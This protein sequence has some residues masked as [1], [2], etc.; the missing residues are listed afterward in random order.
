V[1]RF[2]IEWGVNQRLLVTPLDRPVKPGD[3]KFRMKSTIPVM[4]GLG[5]LLSGLKFDYELP[6]G[7]W[8][9][10]R[11]VIAPADTRRLILARR[12]FIASMFTSGMMIAASVRRSG[13]MASKGY[14]RSGMGRR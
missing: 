3:G 1:G 5:P 10:V 13:Q 4:R 6:C 7:L 9:A 2:V 11:S 14:A 8:S 12:S